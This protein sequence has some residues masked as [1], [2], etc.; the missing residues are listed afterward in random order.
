M[1]KI[2]LL[3][4]LTWF[5][6]LKA[7][8]QIQPTTLKEFKAGH[9]FYISLP[10]YMNKTV[11]LNSASTIQF[12]NAVKDVYGFV[13]EDT[14]E[15]LVMADMQ[16][17]SINEF[18]DNFIKDFLKDQEKRTVSAA[19]YSESEGIK[20]AE[21]DASYYDKEIKA[22]IYY[23]VGVVETK[24]AFYKVVSWAALENKDR[25]KSDFQK[26]LYSLRD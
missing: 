10:E 19:K 26:I 6:T 7:A 4:V 17:T 14:K 25:F 3:S 12:K 15:D 22:S 18:Y 13:I 11:G 24:S 2:A 1:K 5:F 9:V 16:F 21:S 8:A 23:L 20:F